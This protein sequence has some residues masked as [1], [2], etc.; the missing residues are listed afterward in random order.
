MKAKHVGIFWGSAFTLVELLVVLVVIT[1]LSALILSTLSSA[2]ARARQTQCVNNL[3]EHG[4]AL[5]QFLCEHHAY[6]LLMNG[7]QTGNVTI[8]DDNSYWS[9]RIISWQDVLGVYS[10]KFRISKSRKPAQPLGIWHCPTAN[11]PPT[12]IFPT[13][14]VFEDYGYNGYGMSGYRDVSG[15]LGLSH[16]FADFVN[17][18]VSGD[19]PPFDGDRPVGESEVSV[20]ASMIAIGDGF[21][22]QGDVIADGKGCLGRHSGVVGFANSTE[23]SYRRHW[24]KAE[25]VFCDGHSASLPLKSLFTETNAAFL[26]MWNRDHQPHFDRLT[27]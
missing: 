21:A 13:K 23:R 22:G 11:P 14:L 18:G 26:A 10:T 24:G 3:H 12:P 1:V 16:I 25:V 19:P 15:S 20:P 27:P 5:A 6:S 9:E 4:I 7:P 17:C 8:N 2:A